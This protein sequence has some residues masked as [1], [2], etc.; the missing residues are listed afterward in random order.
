MI[1]SGDFIEVIGYKDRQIGLW[2]CAVCRKFETPRT[3]ELNHS[4]RRLLD[5]WAR[6]RETQ[7]ICR[8][9]ADAECFKA[10]PAGGE[11]GIGY[12]PEGGIADALKM[13]L[14]A[15]REWRIDSR[16]G[17]AGRLI[18]GGPLIEPSPRTFTFARVAPKYVQ[19][20][21]AGIDAFHEEAG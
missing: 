8:G 4:V 9:K 16:R 14:L 10:A 1:V 2:H 19:H 3:D 6:R 11:D 7:P 15:G 13:V 12:F 18:F 20:E 17:L 5:K 21:A